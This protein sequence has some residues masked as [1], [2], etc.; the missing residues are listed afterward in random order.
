MRTA[1]ANPNGL[2]ETIPRKVRN[3][4]RKSLCC[5]LLAAHSSWLLAA[6][7]ADP[8]ADLRDC[9]A[10]A[11]DAKRLACYDAIARPRPEPLAPA[12]AAGAVAPTAEEQFGYRGNLAREELDH[13]E[14]KAQETKLEQIV[15]RVTA[16]S[17]QPQGEFVITLDND[18][19]WVQKRPEAN[20]RPKVGDEVTIKAGLLGSFLLVTKSGRSTRVARFR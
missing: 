10:Q 2:S 8:L 7:S 16:V 3:V 17:A 19:V 20:V 6:A 15:A 12:A 4:I 1:V 11:D 13:E 14:Q 18:Q 5:C 9:A